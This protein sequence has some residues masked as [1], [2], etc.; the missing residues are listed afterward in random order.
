MDFSNSQDMDIE[1]LAHYVSENP[2]FVFQD[3]ENKPVKEKKLKE[4]EEEHRE[5][6]IVPKKSYLVP[7]NYGI[8]KQDLSVFSPALPIQRVPSHILGH[9]VLGRCYVGTT[10]IQIRDDLYGSD[11]YEVD[12]HEMKHAVSPHMSEYSVRLW[13]RAMIGYTRYN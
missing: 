13:T 5:I 8:I 9:G 10:L 1:L 11:F 2:D 12:V 4:P 7:I 3:I 6:L